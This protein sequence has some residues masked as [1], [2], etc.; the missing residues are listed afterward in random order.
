LRGDSCP[1]SPPTHP[2]AAKSRYAALI[3]P[4]DIDHWHTHG[5]VIIERFLSPADLAAVDTSCHRLLPSSDEFAERP[6]VFADVIGSSSRGRGS[7]ASIRYDFP[8]PDSTLNHLTFHPFLVA[9]AERLA[10][11]ED[12]HLSLGHLIAKYAGRGNYDQALHSDYSNNTLVIPSRDKRW[13]DIPMITYLTDVPLD[14]GPTYVV[15]QQHTEHRGLMQ[16]GFRHHTRADFPELYEPGVEKPATVPAG[17]VIIYSMRTFHRGSAM[18][19]EAGHRFVLFSGFHTAG[20]PWMAPKDHTARMGSKEMDKFL[21]EADPRQREALGFP[22]VGH[23][24]WED[25]EMVKGVA[26][27]Y[28]KMDMRPYGGGPPL[29]P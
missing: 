15:S 24:Y 20:A 5:Y 29:E 23:A 7:N 14:L 22:G 12:L 11:T 19:A 26:R 27:R 4:E 8:Y 25:E 16:D 2:Q 21:T 3:R 17:S 13:I 9:F 28:P 10:E 1:P 6:A 18:T